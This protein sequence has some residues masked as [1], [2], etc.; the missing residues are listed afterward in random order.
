MMTKVQKAANSIVTTLEW[1]DVHMRNA[2]VAAGEIHLLLVI[3]DIR[4]AEFHLND[5]ITRL[6]SV[7]GNRGE[8]LSRGTVKKKL[9]R[10]LTNAADGL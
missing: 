4:A 6:E 7:A 8:T 5:A 9:K 10:H 3:D 2:R 1:A